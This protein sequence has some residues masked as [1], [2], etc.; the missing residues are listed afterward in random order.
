MVFRKDTEPSCSYCEYGCRISNEEVMCRKKGVVSSAGK[1]RA[2]R[3]DA[4]KR[5]PAPPA[6]LKTDGLTEED[7]KL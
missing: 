5:E 7:F 4:L 6:V 3:Y 1:C 2:F